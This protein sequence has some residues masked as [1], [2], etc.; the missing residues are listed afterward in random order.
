[1]AYILR[2]VYEGGCGPRNNLLIVHRLRTATLYV[3]GGPS[4]VAY[5]NGMDD[6][7]H[8]N[9]APVAVADIDKGH[10]GTYWEPNGG[11][12]AQVVVN[13]LDWQL[14]GDPEAESVFLGP[15]CALCVD[16]KWTFKAKGLAG[17]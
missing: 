2:S 8:I 13:W 3:L 14:R 16:P 5:P 6:F 7:E 10:G 12:A 4:D 15:N 17:R 11:A 9:H 1:M